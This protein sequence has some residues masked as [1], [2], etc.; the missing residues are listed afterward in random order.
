M[1]ALALAPCL[2]LAMPALAGGFEGIISMKI[3]SPAGS[4]NV[5]MSV[6]KVGLRSEID[7]Q[8]AQMPMKMTMLVKHAQDT[9]YMIDDKSKTYTEIDLK[10][11]REMAQKADVKYTAKKLG[12]E[13]VAGYKCDHLM[14]SD[15]K[16]GEH[17]LWTNKEIMDYDSFVKMMGPNARMGD[18]GLMKALKDVS[19]DGFIVKM[20]QRR[21]GAKEATMTMELL[22]V[23]KKSLPAATFEVPSGCTKREGAMM[24][25]PPEVEAQMRERMKNMTPEQREMMKKAM[26]GKMNPPPSQ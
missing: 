15:D 10:K 24:G 26:Q 23:E 12:T 21:A 11:G 5:Q 6:G 7:M 17:E 9:A 16:G 2:F 4:G 14:V 25:M 8:S 3:S 19:A 20:I 13:T 22:K 1:K 18:Q